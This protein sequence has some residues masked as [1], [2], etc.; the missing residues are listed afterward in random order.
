MSDT[1][2]A[3]LDQPLQKGAADSLNI[4]DYAVTLANIIHSCET[5]MT[6]GIQGE[7]GSGKTSL[8]HLIETS[9]DTDIT[10]A[11]SGRGLNKSG[12]S[13]NRIIWINTWEH[14]LLKSP[15]QCLISILEEIIDEIASVDG[16]LK[17]AQAAK[18]A[19]TALARGAV[20]VGA[21][22]AFGRV[23]GDV[24]N[25]IVGAPTSNSVKQLRSSLTSIISDIVLN[26]SVDVQKFVIIVDDLDRLEPTMAVSILELLKNIFDVKHC[27]FVLAIDYQV[28]VKG[29]K[30]KFGEPTEHNEWEFRAFFDKIIQLPFMMPIGRYG[31]HEYVIGL[32]RTIKFFT[33]KEFDEIFDK[34]LS[35]MVK[36][37]IGFNPRA[38]KRLVNSL[39]LIYQLNGGFSNEKDVLLK[40]LMN[41]TG[42]TPITF[43]ELVFA[44]VC[45]QI[46]FPKIYEILL[47]H[48]EF[49][50]WDDNI[51]SKILRPLSAELNPEMDRALEQAMLSYEEDFDEDWEQ[52][53]FKIVWIGK[54]NR[55]KIL[56]ASRLLSIIKD[57]V[58]GDELDD[59]MRDEIFRDILKK[60][61]VTAVVSTGEN[62][63]TESE[64]NDEE[65]LLI[66]DKREFWRNI[67]RQLDGSGC[68]FDRKK[69][70]ISDMHSGGYIRRH[71]EKDGSVPGEF[72]IDPERRAKTPLRFEI[73]Q[74]EISSNFAL[75]L[76]LQE[77]CE[78]ELSDLT[79]TLVRFKL[80]DKKPRQAI[81]FY[82]N[83]KNNNSGNYFVRS[84][85][86]RKELCDWLVRVIPKAEQAIRGAIASFDFDKS[87][88]DNSA[89]T[90]TKDSY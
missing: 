72:H 88:F 24:A 29:L 59:D 50:D 41:K 25:E 55:S 38:I 46:S 78:K 37:S 12:S 44:L 69:Q 1:S 76:H 32:L 22:M 63:T 11:T 18:G 39:S 80:S 74:G 40:Q 10:I 83:K 5:P 82:F 34:R 84:Q 19:L 21:T 23:G 15:E 71:L 68:A 60:S 43:K 70:R 57:T 56:E 20:R 17:A 61:A 16:S 8:M 30:G 75:F 66:R 53:L 13:V 90:E 49:W 48:P 28:V 45:I 31:M 86:E 73:H 36:L 51:V 67:G 47:I 2:I 64:V 3:V 87:S 33:T 58:L 77:K 4:K 7:W 65:A 26:K 79:G 85:E 54:Y 52:A 14:S 27:V 42:I 35:E 6:I 9:M 62:V 81:L 89:V